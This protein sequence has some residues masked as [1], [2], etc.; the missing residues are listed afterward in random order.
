MSSKVSNVFG[1]NGQN[2]HSETRNEPSYIPQDVPVD[3]TPR[4]ITHILPYGVNKGRVFQ[5]IEGTNAPV[6]LVDDIGQAD[7]LLTTKNYYR[8]RTQAL[9]V[10]EQRGKPVYVLRK[11]T[12]PQIQQFIQAITRKSNESDV[13]T[14]EEFVA[15]QEAEEAAVRLEEGAVQV[16]LN[17]QGAFIRHLQHKIADR[18]GLASSSAGRDPKRHV[19]MYKR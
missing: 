1:Q 13:P 8:R 7:L 2:R 17:P 4:K 5:A 6:E 10:A 3:D 9:R 16:D 18:Y 12:L 14:D 19:V 15:V 11:N